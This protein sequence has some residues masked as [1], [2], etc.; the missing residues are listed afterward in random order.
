MGVKAQKGSDD[1]HMH[2]KQLNNSNVS[3]G[4]TTKT[5]PDITKTRPFPSTLASDREKPLSTADEKRPMQLYLNI[6]EPECVRINQ[7]KTHHE[8]LHQ[9]RFP[10]TGCRDEW[11][12]FMVRGA[13]FTQHDIPA[14]FANSDIVPKRLIS[15]TEARAIHNREMR[16]GNVNYFVNAYVHFYKHDQHFD[17]LH[18]A[19]ELNSIWTN[20]WA[21]LKLLRHFTGV[22]SPDFSTNGNLPDPIKR[23][24]IYKMRAYDFW[25]IKLGISVIYNVRYGR[26]F[27]RDYCLDG[28][29]CH[30]TVAVGAIASKLKLRRNR[31]LYVE[32]LLY[33]VEKKSPRRIIVYGGGELP[34]YDLF[35]SR[36]INV[37]VF[38]SEVAAAFAKVKRYAQAG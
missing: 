9:K 16:A 20:P 7:S 23:D 2:V 8:K 1:R 24:N 19:R 26:G 22:I 10:F 11:N 28:I 18:H 3:G 29:P 35:R 31:S 6:F 37:D 4:I 12:L 38:P 17:N 25:L 34:F 5:P 33:L 13:L 15:F 21:A 27:M 30:A 14:S 36:G 32:G